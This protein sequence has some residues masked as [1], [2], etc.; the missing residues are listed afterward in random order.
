MIER[1][2]PD[3]TLSHFPMCGQRT[4]GKIKEISTVQQPDGGSTY[5]TSNTISANRFYKVL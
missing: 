2:V 4:G 1:F 5:S 3:L